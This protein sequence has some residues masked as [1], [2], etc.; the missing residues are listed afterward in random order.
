MQRLM[1]RARHSLHH[2]MNEHLLLSHP[3]NH[4]QWMVVRTRAPWRWVMRTI[5]ARFYRRDDAVTAWEEV[6]FEEFKAET[7]GDS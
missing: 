6:T 5:S 2:L 1:A 7:G 3:D 4:V